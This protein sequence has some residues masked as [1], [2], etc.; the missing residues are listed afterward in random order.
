[1]QASFPPN[2]IGS[3]ERRRVDRALR[4]LW[5]VD[6][7]IH[8]LWR[9]ARR[10]P[11]R[12][13]TT[14]RRAVRPIGTCTAAGAS[15]LDLRRVPRPRAGNSG[16]VRGALRVGARYPRPSARNQG[17]LPALPQLP[18]RGFP[19]APRPGGARAGPSGGCLQRRQHYRH[20][21][22]QFLNPSCSSQRL[23]SHQHCQ[24]HCQKTSY[25]RSSRCRWLSCQS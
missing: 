11:T 4:A 13:P 9:V 10:V 12:A 23:G 20:P 16:R 6:G 25:P 18:R 19:V 1:M 15:R 21:P 22:T 8:Q 14:A 3:S 5:P 2:L 17:A 7:A 24:H